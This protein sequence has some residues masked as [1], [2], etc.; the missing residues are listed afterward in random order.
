MTTLQIPRDDWQTAFDRISRLHVGEPI[1]VEVLRPDFGAQVQVAG[2]P[3]DG[4][5]A[6]LD[7]GCAITI[8][9]G[10]SLDDHIAHLVA[11]PVQ[12]HVLRSPTD[13]DEVIEIRAGDGS[14]TLLH[15][16]AS[17]GWSARDRGR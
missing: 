7:D 15:F 5:S 4:I 13:D 2:L 3:F 8:A 16:E 1:R 12:V 14:T 6:D 10:S 9:A 17:R 11:D